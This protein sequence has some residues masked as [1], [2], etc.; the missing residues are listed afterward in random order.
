MNPV[1]Y[2]NLGKRSRKSRKN[3]RKSKRKT[4]CWKG[5]H[6]VKGTTPYAKHS[7]IKNK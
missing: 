1:S 7:C 5:Y 6:R 2:K 4:I 3:K